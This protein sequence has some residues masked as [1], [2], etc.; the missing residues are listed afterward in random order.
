MDDRDVQRLRIIG[1][2]QAEEGAYEREVNRLRRQRAR[3]AQRIRKFSRQMSERHRR[4]GEQL[5]GKIASQIA[6]LETKQARVRE[7]S[8]RISRE[9]DQ[10]QD[11]LREL[12]EQDEADEDEA[13]EAKGP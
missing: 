3:F 6:R 2:L 9:P 1:D 7:Y 10:A 8:E 11:L 13:E 4:E 12:N 5:I